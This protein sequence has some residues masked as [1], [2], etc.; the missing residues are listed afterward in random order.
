[1]VTA[2]ARAVGA[3]SEPPLRR[4]VALSLILAVS[5]FAALWLAFLVNLTAF[6]VTSGLLPYV[7]RDVYHA[8]QTGLG[9]LISSFAFGS[10]LGSILISIIGRSIR[11]VC[12]GAI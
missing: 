12:S 1:M 11:P 6:P 9:S 2:L 8:D 7:A 10:L 5:T 3:L 4:V